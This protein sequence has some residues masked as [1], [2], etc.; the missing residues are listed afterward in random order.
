MISSSARVAGAFF[1]LYCS[2]QILYSCHTARIQAAMP[3]AHPIPGTQPAAASVQSMASKSATQLNPT[4]A[5]QAG[6]LKTGI[7]PAIPRAQAARA[8]SRAL[9]HGS[10]SSSSLFFRQ[11][12]ELSIVCISMEEPPTIYEPPPPPPPGDPKP[13]EPPPPPPPPVAPQEEPPPRPPLQSP[14]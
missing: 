8:L 5:T 7:H 12:A 3:A 13:Q 2:L 1:P 4:P 14:Y 9:A 10:P 6:M 11:S